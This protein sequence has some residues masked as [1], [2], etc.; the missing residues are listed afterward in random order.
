MVDADMVFACLD[1]TIETMMSK[2]PFPMY[3]E[4]FYFKDVRAKYN[5]A[6]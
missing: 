6:G 5:R 4:N 3:F 1:V 2:M